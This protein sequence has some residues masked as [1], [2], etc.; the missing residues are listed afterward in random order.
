VTQG[1]HHLEAFEEALASGHDLQ[2]P[3][4]AQPIPELPVWA[5]PKVGAGSSS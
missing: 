3:R 2:A 5:R 4:G 1:V